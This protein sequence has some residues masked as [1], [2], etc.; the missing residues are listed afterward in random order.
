MN[1]QLTLWQVIAAYAFAL[2]GGWISTSLHLA[3]KPLC[4]LISF[5]AGLPGFLRNRGL[6]FLMLFANR[7]KSPA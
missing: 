2:A 3:H 4:A 6:R 1:G 5:A 7:R